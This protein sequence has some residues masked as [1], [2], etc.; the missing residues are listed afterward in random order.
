MIQLPKRF[1]WTI[2][3]ARQ[4]FNTDNNIRS[5][6]CCPVQELKRKKGGK[7]RKEKQYEFSVMCFLSTAVNRYFEE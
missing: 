4:P 1:L 7:G 3:F 2:N 6:Q 5:E